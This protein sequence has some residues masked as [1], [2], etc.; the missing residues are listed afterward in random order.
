MPPST[1]TVT[2]PEQVTTE[3]IVTTGVLPDEAF[4]PDPIEV[5]P[6][7]LG[8]FDQIVMGALILGAVLPLGGKKK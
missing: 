3:P 2:P 4:E 1:V 7:T 6:R 8:T 5:T